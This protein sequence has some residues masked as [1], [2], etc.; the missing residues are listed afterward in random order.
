MGH[1]HRAGV[2]VDLIEAVYLSR[3]RSR[4]YWSWA[5]K[6]V[7]RAQVFTVN[8]GLQHACLG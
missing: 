1:T 7:R 4:V 2:A 3:D 5:Q 8:C 6:L